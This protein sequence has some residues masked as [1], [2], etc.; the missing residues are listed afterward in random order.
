MPVVEE[1]VVQQGAA[2]ERALVE[3]DIQRAR[4]A[5]AHAGCADA[6]CVD[7]DVAMLHEGLLELHAFRCK[8]VP[9]VRAHDFD[10]RFHA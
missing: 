2:H 10:R 1:V 7:A 4:D 3:P 6:V 5:D 8:D 9:A